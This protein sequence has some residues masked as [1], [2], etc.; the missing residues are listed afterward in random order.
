MELGNSRSNSNL[1][2][3]VAESKVVSLGVTLGPAL[4]ELFKLS[5]FHVSFY[6]F[7]S[8]PLLNYYFC[9]SPTSSYMVRVISCSEHL[10]FRNFIS[11][12]YGIFLFQ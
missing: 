3:S 4:F 6:P 10:V 11:S 9:F 5:H 2:K 1:D 7:E 8:V 12:L